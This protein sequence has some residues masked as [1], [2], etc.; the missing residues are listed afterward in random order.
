MHIIFKTSEKAF[1]ESL[2]LPN[3]TSLV[4]ESE[5]IKSKFGLW[6]IVNRWFVKDG[7]W[8]LTWW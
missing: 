1:V 4:E 3:R 2:D 7:V 6:A 5:T 8:Y